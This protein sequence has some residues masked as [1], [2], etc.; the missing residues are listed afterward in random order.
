MDYDTAMRWLIVLLLAPAFARAEEVTWPKGVYACAPL[1]CELLVPEGWTIVGDRT[2]F[3]AIG[4]GMGMVVSREPLFHDEKEFAAVWQK[5]IDA[6]GRK[7][8]VETF[9]V[10]R[11]SAWGAAWEAAVESGMR[12]IRVAR[13]Y[14]PDVE[15]LYNVSLSA[16]AGGADL[17]AIADGALKGFKFTGSRPK[18]A[19]QK[20]VVGAERMSVP[21]MEGYEELPREVVLGGGAGADYAK[22]LPGYGSPHLAGALNLDAFSANGVILQDGSILSGT[23][24]KGAVETWFRMDQSRFPE[25]TA[26]PKIRSWWCGREKAQCIEVG[27]RGPDGLPKLYFAAACR[28]K[29]TTYVVEL[30]VD[31][32]EERLYKDLFKQL[33][34]EVSFKE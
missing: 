18:L 14:V 26:K 8:K 21:L 24:L 2:G 16:P 34:A 11:L 19:F 30:I 15:M 33:C 3:S 32:R 28:V 13:V 22:V 6:A 27:V 20:Q 10:G 17:K 25:I 23:D 31:A 7:A 4:Q 5:Q 29:Q 1:E 9:R 12:A